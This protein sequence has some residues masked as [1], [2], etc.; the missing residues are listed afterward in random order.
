MVHE[1][2]RHNHDI[3]E[4]CCSQIYLE[5]FSPRNP[6]EGGKWGINREAAVQR[7]AAVLLKAPGRSARTTASRF[8]IPD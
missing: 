3:H 2:S 5:P 4:C 1:A 7:G 8:S 6:L